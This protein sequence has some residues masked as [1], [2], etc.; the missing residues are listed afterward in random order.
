MPASPGLWSRWIL[1]AR[2]KIKFNILGHKS[3]FYPPLD[4]KPTS[5]NLASI[6]ILGSRKQK[7]DTR[8]MKDEVG[9]P[10]CQALRIIPDIAQFNKMFK[11]LLSHVPDCL[12]DIDLVIDI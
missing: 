5:I 10:W 4:K 12:E 11:R 7:E 9:P 8:W 6:I 3:S 2:V 1:K